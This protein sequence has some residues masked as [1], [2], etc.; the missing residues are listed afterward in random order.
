M[1]TSV[2]E[3]TLPPDW[4]AV[5]G[6]WDPCRGVLV[7]SGLGEDEA[8][9]LAMVA[10]ELLENAVKYGAGDGDGIRLSLR[11]DEGDVTVEVRSRLGVDEEH[12]RTFDRT[13]QWI[14]GYQ[15]PF[16][17]YVERLK[18]T[19]AEPYDPSGGGLGLARIAYEG[20]CALDFYVDA[21][22]VLSVS[23]VYRRGGG[24]A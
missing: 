24:A 12:L 14:R 1:E 23:A 3:L 8:Y 22:S 9:S 5:R 16:E 17:A 11:V 20:R 4:S 15:D 6:V 19:A 10:Q 7:R 13:V 18:A 2:L 21:A